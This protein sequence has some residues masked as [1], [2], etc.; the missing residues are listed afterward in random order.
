MYL[1]WTTVEYELNW[2]RKDISRFPEHPLSIDT[3]YGSMWGLNIRYTALREALKEYRNAIIDYSLHRIK[4]LQEYSPV[5]TKNREMPRCR[6]GYGTFGWKYDR[7][8]IEF[9]IENRMLI[10]TAEGY[11][12]G[13]V[14][15]ELGKII[16]G[17]TEVEIMS[18]VRRDHMSPNAIYS[19]IERSVQKLTV[20]S[21]FQLH[22]PHIKYP[23]AIKDL[24]YTR[25]IG[26]TKAIGLSNTSVDMIEMGQNL[27]SDSTGDP[28]SFV[29]MPY[30]VINKRI[31]EIFL[32]Y[33]QRHGIYIVAYSPL[34]Q[35]GNVVDTPLIR[36]IAK[37]YSA[38][39]Q[40]VALAYL[41]SHPGVIPI[42]TTNNLEHLK[43]N[44]EANDLKLDSSDIETIKMN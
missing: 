10:D 9:A 1:D 24:G 13:R 37:K 21:H 34:G 25:Q 22:F 15:T 35:I 43:Q 20:C 40:Q 17:N 18:K 8:L 42:P 44:V 3:L 4:A 30:N 19:S 36:Q 28:I 41:L 29:Q 27:L 38:T 39:S 7:K 11:G 12:Y 32:P 16:N 14:E 23:E 33:C 26:K 5:Y 6:I 2:M 31:E